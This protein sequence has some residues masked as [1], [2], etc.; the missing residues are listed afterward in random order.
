MRKNT[1]V[2]LVMAWAGS[3]GVPGRCAPTEPPTSAQFEFFE[4]RIR[5]VLVA[6]CYSCHN[7]T[8]S[9]QGGLAV[10]QRAALLRGG[11]GGAAV[12]PGKPEKSRLFAAIAHTLPGLEM[13]KGGAKLDKG[14]LA[15][16][17]KWIAMGAPDPRGKPPTVPP[18]AT[19]AT[20]WAATLAARKQWWCFQPIK[21]VAPPVT[22]GNRW[23]DHPIDRFLYA[24]M[25]QNK[26][27]PA[28]AAEPATLVRRTYFALVGLPPTPDDVKTW[29]ARLKTPGGMEALV[30]HLLASPQYGETWARHGMD[31]VRYADS[32]G[33]EGDPEIV[34]GWQFRDYLI[35]ALNADVPYDQLVR[36]QISG[37]LLS[38]P[39]VNTTLGINESAIGPAH[40]RMVFHGFA[41]TDALEEKVRF[42]DDE[43]N[44]FSKAF[45]GLTVACARCH[46]HKFDAISQYLRQNGRRIPE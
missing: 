25:A 9:A 5:P 44:T 12:V 35:R 22:A 30:D 2:L 13:P 36:E 33:S 16:F 18:T 23:S 14:V 29:T 34:N 11:N 39:R 26:L 40:W 43:I 7:S 24:R 19:P 27:S 6:R 21:N 8:V 32:Q 3:L 41:P 38:K 37:D 20:S 15:D 4:S 42:T 45:L 46:D 17:A 1:C 31:W 28:P 10:D